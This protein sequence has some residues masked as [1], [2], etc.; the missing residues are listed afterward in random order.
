VWKVLTEIHVGA[1]LMR[2]HYMNEQAY[3]YLSPDDSLNTF[4]QTEKN[5]CA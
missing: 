4:Y 1:L 2:D 5:T 3:L